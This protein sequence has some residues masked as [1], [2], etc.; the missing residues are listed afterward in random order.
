MVRDVEERQG[1]RERVG[2]VVRLG[3]AAKAE[4]LRDHRA[5]LLLAR[6][7]RA[8]ERAFH[9]GVTERVDGYARLRARQAQDA[10]CVAHQ[11]RGTR[12]R[13]RR[14]QFFDHDDRGLRLCDDL[15]DAFVQLA[16]ASLEG[17]AHVRNDHARLD[18]HRAAV[19]PHD[20]AVPGRAQGGVYP[21]DPQVRLR[22]YGGCGPLTLTP[23][24]EPGASAVPAGGSVPITFPP[25]PALVVYCH[26]ETL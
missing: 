12:I 18:E 13:V 10:A 19:V 1:Q 26:F 8:D 6:A 25:A 16:Q 14:V 24:E 15:A 22:H 9:A 20:R 2:D 7:P 3:P 5:Y 11:Q 21:E 4:Q 23:T 17:R